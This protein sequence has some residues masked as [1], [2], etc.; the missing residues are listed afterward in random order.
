MNEGSVHG[1][2]ISTDTPSK[3]DAMAAPRAES[4][5][6]HDRETL[7]A[8]DELA[9]VERLRGLF[10]QAEAAR[11]EQATEIHR[12]REAVLDLARWTM[13]YPSCARNVGADDYSCGLQ[14]AWAS[15]QDGRAQT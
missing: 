1:Q 2:R 5:S 3:E 7:L 11:A 8:A 12:L 15:A 6:R 13:H 14:Q 9:E 4:V 10:Q